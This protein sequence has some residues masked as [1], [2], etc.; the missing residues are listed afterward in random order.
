M[1][2]ESVSAEGTEVISSVEGT[3]G[4]SRSVVRRGSVCVGIYRCGSC[5]LQNTQKKQFPCATFCLWNKAE[6][7]DFSHWQTL[8]TPCISRES[9]I[10]PTTLLVAHPCRFKRPEEELWYRRKICASQTQRDIW[11][12]NQLWREGHT[13][14]CRCTQSRDICFDATAL[15]AYHNTQIRKQPL[16]KRYWISFPFRNR[17]WCWSNKQHQW[18]RTTSFS[19]NQ[20]NKQRLTKHKRSQ[21]YRNAP[22]SDSN[23]KNE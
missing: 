12:G 6:R 3:Y 1:F 13:R 7:N 10:S 20:K 14:A 2:W 16:E 23:T 15:Q 5:T 11:D 17:S 18:K 8:S 19:D 21:C 9:K 22:L 4:P